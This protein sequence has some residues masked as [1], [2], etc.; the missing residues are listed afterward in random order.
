MLTRREQQKIID[1]HPKIK[2]EVNLA[3]K[4]RN[5]EA[6]VATLVVLILIII[7]LQTIA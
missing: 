2:K 5:L 1:S 6:I 3:K 7:Y 4:N